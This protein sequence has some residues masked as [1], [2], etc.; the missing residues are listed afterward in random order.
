MSYVELKESPGSSPG[1]NTQSGL[2]NYPLAPNYSG[3]GTGP[4]GGY[5]YS[6][7]VLNGDDRGATQTPATRDSIVKLEDDKDCDDNNDDKL[8][9]DA[10][11]FQDRYEDVCHNNYVTQYVCI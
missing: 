3:Q 11:V 2:P 9:D 4:T 7:P 5:Q 8:A 6:Y 1:G 10:P